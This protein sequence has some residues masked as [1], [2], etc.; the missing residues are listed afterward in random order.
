MNAPIGAPPTLEWIGV[1]RLAI[2]ESYQR[3]TDST[4]SRRLIAGIAAAWNWNLCQPLVISRRTDGAL[5]VIDGQ[6]RLSGAIARGDIPHLPCVVVTGADE[7]Q[8]FIA[9]N[10]KRQKLSQGDVFNAMLAAGDDAAKTTAK[11]L[12]ETGWT[13]TRNH[14]ISIVGRLNCAPM[15]AKAVRKM[16]EC[17]VRNALTALREAYPDSPVPNAATLLRAL[18]VIY[19]D[20]R[21]PDPD[22]LIELLGA[23]LPA[24]WQLESAG[25]RLRNPQ[26][27]REEALIE[28]IVSACVEAVADARLAA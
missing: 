12:E 10:S 28:T 6:H 23:V 18:F 22:L 21:A 8:T 11:I 7:A 2:D 13:L 4:S 5:Y 25:L 26:L 16:G 24:D 19:R 9:L 1:E 17:P 14:T 15:I 3:A 20:K 27:S